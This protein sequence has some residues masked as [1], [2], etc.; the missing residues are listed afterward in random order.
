L[1]LDF[2]IIL[3]GVH[4]QIRT[5]TIL[6][7]LVKNQALNFSTLLQGCNLLLKVNSSR[8]VAL[9]SKLALEAQQF[10]IASLFELEF[11]LVACREL[12]FDVL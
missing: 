10:R 9:D 11:D 2:P 6:L 12:V 4:E 1:N 7:D 3:L 5:E 8:H